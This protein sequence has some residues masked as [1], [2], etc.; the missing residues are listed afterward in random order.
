MNDLW[1]KTLSMTVTE[2]TW[3]VYVFLIVLISLTLNFIQK[4]FLAKIHA[5]LLTTNNPWDDALVLAAQ[6]PLTWFIWLVG[7][8]LSIDVIQYDNKVPVFETIKPLQYVAFILILTIFLLRLTR[9]IELVFKTSK[10]EE[11]S[12]KY[13][14]ATVEAISKLL[15]ASAIITG[16]LVGLQTLGFSISGV[17]AFGGIGGV[18]IGFAAKD[19]LANFFGGLI[20][21]LD[22]PFIIGDWI[23]SSDREIEG[24]VENIGW[25]LTT[26]RTFDKR[27]LYV[28]NSVF[29]NISV[30]N[31]SR[32][33]N[34]RIYETIGVRYD[35]SQ[36]IPAIIKD[37]RDMLETHAEIDNTQTLI[38]N[39]NQFAPSSMDFFIYVF[40]KTTE[41]VYFHEVKQDVLLKVLEIV[42]KHG[43]EV[44]FPTST[45]HIDS[46]KSEPVL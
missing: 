8:I 16:V 23:R 4:R 33:S 26:I 2:D 14:I 13:E 6:K 27:P 9:E 20:I 5:K 10:D 30:E 42:S 3:I 46:Q 19:L 25:R 29:S 36:K 43:A 41:W 11:G 7:L 1:S 39:F 12:N 45:L 24:I 15:R 18:A 31:P 37:V 35:D 44:A 40:T 22:R 34:R 17:L 32:M 38:V 21:Y 28:P